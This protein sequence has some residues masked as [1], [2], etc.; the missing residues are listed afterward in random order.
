MY[1]KMK[2]GGVFIDGIN[3]DDFSNLCGQGAY[4][5]TKNIQKILAY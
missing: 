4:L 5:Q 2:I 3:A 1:K